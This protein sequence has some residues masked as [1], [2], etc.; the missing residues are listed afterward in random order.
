[1]IKIE[2]S[3]RVNDDKFP[4]QIIAKDYQNDDNHDKDV[5]VLDFCL[6]IEEMESITAQFLDVILQ[7]R[8]NKED[9]DS[10][11]LRDN[12]PTIYGNW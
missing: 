11:R 2:Y 3:E 12:V 10:T 6:S 5:I 4:I 9:V 1:M 7:I 8:K